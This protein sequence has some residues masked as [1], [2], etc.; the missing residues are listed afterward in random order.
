MT[1]A[2]LLSFP[3]DLSASNGWLVEFFLRRGVVKIAEFPK[4]LYNFST[5]L[6]FD[7]FEAFVLFPETL[8]RLRRV[9]TTF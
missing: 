4:T 7:L 5:W 8:R 2:H 9:R 6:L 1:F 3:V